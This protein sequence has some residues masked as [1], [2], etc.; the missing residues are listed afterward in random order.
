MLFIRELCKERHV[1]CP[2]TV[3]VPTTHVRASRVQPAPP[4]PELLDPAHFTPKWLHLAG[5]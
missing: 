2:E 1:T 5:R 3:P 4:L